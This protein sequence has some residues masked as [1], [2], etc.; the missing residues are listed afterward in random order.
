MRQGRFD[1]GHVT[2]GLDRRATGGQRLLVTFHRGH[3]EPQ[4]VGQV[5]DGEHR[6]LFGSLSAQPCHQGT[7]QRRQSFTAAQFQIT[8]GAERQP[9]FDHA[10]VS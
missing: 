1:V 8:I 4:Q 6:L 2:A 10:A 7:D 5:F 9:D 3:Q